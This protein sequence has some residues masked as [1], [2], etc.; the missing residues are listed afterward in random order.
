VQQN[1]IWL[2]SRLQLLKNN[3]DY[4]LV[5]LEILKYT[6]PG[7]VV[8][9]AVYFTLNSYLASENK[10]K[11]ME[12]RSMY[13]RESLPIRL[14]A[15]ERMTLFLERISPTNLI[16]RINKPDMTAREMHLS[17]LQNIKLEYEHNLSQQLYLPPDTWHTIVGV[18]EEI[19]SIINQVA[20]DVPPNASAKD[21]SRR[22]LEYFISTEDM[23]PTQK[24]LN[25]LKQEVTKIF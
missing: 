16:S 17:I 20:I 5:I 13:F 14:Q 21:L 3:M 23:L 22:I 6:I 25:I 18:K 10:R 1:E 15:Y 19:I 9:L 12:I 4:I 11:N 7:L 2:T 8:F 24:A